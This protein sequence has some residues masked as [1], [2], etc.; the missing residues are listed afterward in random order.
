MIKAFALL[1]LLICFLS[2]SAYSKIGVWAY[3]NAPTATFKCFASQGISN[4]LYNSY[5]PPQ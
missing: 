3:N 4:Y 2:H 1:T 5:F